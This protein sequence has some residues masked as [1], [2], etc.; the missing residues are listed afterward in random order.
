MEGIQK[1]ISEK[2]D[3]LLEAQKL[4]AEFR[5]SFAR[6]YAEFIDKDGVID[7]VAIMKNTNGG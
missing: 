5:N 1:A 4:M 2:K 3:D 7:W 6:R